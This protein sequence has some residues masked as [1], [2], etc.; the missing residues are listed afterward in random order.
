MGS[1][2][3]DLAGAVQIEPSG[4]Q[5]LKPA[6][7]TITL[8]GSADLSKLTGFATAGGGEDFGLYPLETGAGLVMSLSHFSTYGAA[9][10]TDTQAA[11]ALSRMPERTQAQY[12]QLAGDI[13]RRARESGTT[14]DAHALAELSAAYYRDILGP[15]TQKALTDDTYE[16]SAITELLGW[17]RQMEL[18]GLKDDPLVKPFFDGYQALLAKIVRNAIQQSYQR[19]VQ[20]DDLSEITR[21]LAGE[22]Q[23]Q[24]LG[25]DVGDG[26]ALAQ[27]CAHFELDVMTQSHY[28][29]E[30]GDQGVDADTT[31][32]YAIQI[33]LD[34]NLA[35]SGEQNPDYT[36]WAITV[37]FGCCVTATGFAVDATSSVSGLGFKYDV[38]E[39]KLPD[40]KIVREVP[41]P[42]LALRFDPGAT[43]ELFTAPDGSHSYLTVWN[44]TWTSGHPTELVT[45]QKRLFDLTGWQTLPPGSGQLIASKTYP[46]RT[47]CATYYAGCDPTHTSDKITETTTLKLY[48]RP[49]P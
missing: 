14:P 22:R 12:Q 49:Q 20:T 29:I 10:A 34:A 39:R 48:H 13:I 7:L 35:A 31:V 2:L 44:K 15:L 43:R 18:L 47:F 45:G 8:P 27:K 23:A 41:A 11:A 17:A 28:H 25:L 1:P 38:V 16:A 4:L 19:C 6:S 5:L 9:A 37:Q 3:G 21:L 32:Q 24:L 46:S 30:T 36:Q 40:G 33:S 42:T 26:L